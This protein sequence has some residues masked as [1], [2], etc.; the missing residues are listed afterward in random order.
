MGL[1]GN[2]LETDQTSVT[3]MLGDMI[4]MLYV[5]TCLGQIKNLVVTHL[6]YGKSML[7]TCVLTM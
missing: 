5:Q 4:D 1:V 3:D 2:I 7:R 6:M